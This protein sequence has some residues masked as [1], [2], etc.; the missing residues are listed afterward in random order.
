MLWLGLLR[1]QKGP[2]KVKYIN[3]LFSG[4]RA[5]FCVSEQTAPGRTSYYAHQSSCWASKPALYLAETTEDC[6]PSGRPGG[7]GS[8]GESGYTAEHAK[9]GTAVVV[10]LH[11]RHHLHNRVLQLKAL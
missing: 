11:F 9:T 8:G 2:I 6:V 4:G 3:S 10:T 1:E 7:S 5:Q